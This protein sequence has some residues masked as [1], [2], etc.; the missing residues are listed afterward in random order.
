MYEIKAIAGK[1]AVCYTETI[2][3]SPLPVVPIS[4]YKGT[5]SV[6]VMLLSANA[7]FRIPHTLTI[8]STTEINK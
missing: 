1:W 6:N 2:F 5:L 4:Q 8:R 7:K 3:F